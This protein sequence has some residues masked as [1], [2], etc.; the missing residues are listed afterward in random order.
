MTNTIAIWL[1]LLILG[2]LAVDFHQYDWEMTIYLG[3][4]LVEL[5]EWLAFWR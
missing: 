2:F 1:A 4:K 5:V 3:R